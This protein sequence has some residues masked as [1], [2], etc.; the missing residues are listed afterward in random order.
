M[1]DERGSKRAA[2]LAT[3]LGM[4][5][6]LP[7]LVLLSACSSTGSLVVHVVEEGTAEPLP[8]CEVRI[9]EARLIRQG[10]SPLRFDDVEYRDE[11]YVVSVSSPQ[12]H[13]RQVFRKVGIAADAVISI[14]VDVKLT[15]TGRAAQEKDKRL[16]EDPLGRALDGLNELV[17]R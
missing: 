3:I 17:P 11:P 14:E 4:K 8:E 5:S 10:R 13:F 1:R 12:A 15:E 6:L 9:E 16:A 2:D 7:L